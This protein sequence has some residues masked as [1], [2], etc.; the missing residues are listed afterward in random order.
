MFQKIILILFFE[1]VVFG[2]DAVSQ[3]IDSFENKSLY[4]PRFKTIVEAIPAPLWGNDSSVIYNSQNILIKKNKQNLI[5][6]VKNM[7]VRAEARLMNTQNEI[8]GIFN[9]EPTGPSTAIRGI[10]KLTPTGN[11]IWSKR[12]QISA[13]QFNS[14]SYIANIT[15]GINEDLLLGDAVGNR[16]SLTVL[17]QDLTQIVL[18]KQ[19]QAQLPAGHFFT[20][21]RFEVYSNCIYVFAITSQF[22]SSPASSNLLLL[23]LDY[24]TGNLMKMNYVH[25]SEN[26]TGTNPAGGSFLFQGSLS[27]TMATR[28]TF[29]PAFTIAGRKN[30]N[31]YDN[32]RFYA[33]R[34]DTNLNILSNTIFN[35]PANHRYFNAAV[36][37]APSIDSLGN[38]FFAALRD[39]SNNTN[40]SNNCYFFTADTNARILAQQYINI[41]QTGLNTNGFKL[42]AV[43]FIKKGR[44]AEI[45]FHTNSSQNDS[46]LH[47]VEVPYKVVETAC[48]GSSL[49]YINVEKPGIMILP[50]PQMAVI[51][52]AFYNITDH[53]LL[54][55]DD[56]L[57]ERKFCELKSICDTIKILGSNKFC[58]PNDTAIFKLV[59]NPLCIRKV[60]WLIDTAQMKI[61]SITNDTLI[62]VK[63]RK[64][65]VG[66]LKAKFEN[67]DLI[68][69]IQIEVSQPMQALSAGGDT[70]LCAG[71]QLILRATKGFKDYL[72]QDG[73]TADTI[74]A[75][76][77][78]VYTVKAKDSCD[79]EFTASLN[80]AP[81][82]VSFILD[83]KASICQFD[84]AYINL[85]VGFTG[86]TWSPTV[87]TYNRNNQLVLFP[88]ITTEYNISAEVFPGCSVSDTLLISVKECPIYFYVPNAFTPN[89][90]G[91][92][93]VFKPLIEGPVESYQFAVFNR[94]GNKVFASTDHSKGWNG[95]Y[96][97]AL[98]Q[99]GSFV[100][101][102]TYKLVGQQSISKKGTVLLIR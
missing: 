49:S 55:T 26:F 69:S 65:F 1:I 82:P 92:N 41:T 18:S 48:S 38:I 101:I 31:V 42:N 90:D 66:Y 4:H 100:W 81:A 98:Q 40:T 94:Y 87:N 10:F 45:I 43:P 54:P 88:G 102:C 14:Y 57:D 44:D 79:N 34:V 36:L 5:D 9:D 20:R 17:N 71:K 99:T 24:A 76:A 61:L 68:D 27:E 63:F 37:T 23:K 25:S 84:T 7:N 97:G 86:Y 96:L 8:I 50:N 72:W 29:P 19:F 80:V 67:C 77:P 73:S 64:P 3:C 52:P 53:A 89:N 47:I 22:S 75:L 95:S 59:K 46:V 85:P 39:S 15:E 32:S 21:C 60:E 74:I 91:K 35:T 30:T 70:T 16:I 13:A 51:P 83:F 6:W 12:F 62:K 28:L 56:F 93:D 33:I 78:G 11:L 2:F 58:L